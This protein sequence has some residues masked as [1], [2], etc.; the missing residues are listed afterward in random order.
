MSTTRIKAY[1][2][3]LRIISEQTNL[4]ESAS[5]LNQARSFIIAHHE[6]LLKQYPG[7]WIAAY[8]SD[9]IAADKNLRNLVE[10]IRKSKVPIDQ[11]AVE[12][13]TRDKTP[14]LL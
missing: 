14:I 5:L 10:T 13:L 1:T 12:L 4:I 3:K 2:N 9:V 11:V 7:Y 6:E 8:D